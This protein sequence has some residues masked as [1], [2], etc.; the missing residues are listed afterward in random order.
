MN[1]KFTLR[2]GSIREITYTENEG[3]TRLA[4]LEEQESL[5]RKLAPT[6]SGDTRFNYCAEAQAL[7]D[8][9]FVA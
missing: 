1:I 4:Y 8:A 7:R 5:T 3:T 6:D 9:F 2:N